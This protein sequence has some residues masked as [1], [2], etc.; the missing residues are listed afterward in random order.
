MKQLWLLIA[1]TMVL[2]GI[3]KQLDLQTLLIE[4]V[5]NRAYANGW[6][7]DRRRYQLD[8]IAAMSFAGL[9]ATAGL[10][11]WLR[12]VFSRVYLAIGG[13]AMLVLFVTIRAASFHYV[14]KVLALGG[15]VR[16]NTVIEL[17]GIGLIIAAALQWQLFER[18]DLE[19]RRASAPSAHN[20]SWPPPTMV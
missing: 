8:F 12:R 1:V 10:V 15:E 6:Y 3:N 2:L 7:S 19:S 4:K 13:L 14:D 20:L 18:R 9:L 17:S 11:I 5:R 16:V